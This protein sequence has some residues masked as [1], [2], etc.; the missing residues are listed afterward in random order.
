VQRKVLAKGHRKLLPLVDNILHA[1]FD[2]VQR[3][4]SEQRFRFASHPA[5]RPQWQ[6]VLARLEIKSAC[7]P[8]EHATELQHDTLTRTEPFDLSVSQ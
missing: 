3:A 1:L 7:T 4:I 6:A 8:R 2:L 5:S